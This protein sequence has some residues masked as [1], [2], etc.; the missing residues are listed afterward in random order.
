MQ[1]K[2][3]HIIASCNVTDLSHHDKSVKTIK[4]CQHIIDKDLERIEQ[5]SYWAA[6][7]RKVHKYQLCTSFP[8][9]S[10]GSSVTTTPPETEEAV[11][12]H[13]TQ[14]THHP[15]TIWPLHKPAAGLP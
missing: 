7:W 3:L 8:S 13:M 1:L 9:S 14:Q 5:D 11:Y 10:R 2:C 12:R 6:V 4:I 15:H